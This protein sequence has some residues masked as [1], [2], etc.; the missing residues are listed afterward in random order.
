MTLERVAASPSIRVYRVS[1]FS[2]KTENQDKVRHCS[3]EK[4]IDRQV[5]KRDNLLLF[6]VFTNG[7]LFDKYDMLPFPALYHVQ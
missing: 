5:P 6:H 4:M 2:C 1:K 7:G 3:K